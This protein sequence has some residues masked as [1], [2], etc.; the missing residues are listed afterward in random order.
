MNS[1]LASLKFAQE[2]AETRV[3]SFHSGIKKFSVS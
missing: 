1:L 3:F 2:E